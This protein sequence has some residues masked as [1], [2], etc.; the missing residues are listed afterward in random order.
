M[1][2]NPDG[3]T[4]EL[5]YTGCGCAGGEVVTARD[6]AGRRRKFYKDVLGRLWKVEELNWDQT[7]YSTT[8]YQYNVRDQLELSLKVGDEGNEAGG[9]FLMS[10]STNHQPYC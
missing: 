4:S 8:T 7:L 9:V 6:E 5:S 3:W 1:T 10:F 2:T